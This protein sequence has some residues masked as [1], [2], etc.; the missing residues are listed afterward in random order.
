MNLNFVKLVIKQP[1]SE[2]PERKMTPNKKKNKKKREICI[3]YNVYMLNEVN[4]EIHNILIPK[5]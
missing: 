5:T 1:V 2:S 3:I 4:I